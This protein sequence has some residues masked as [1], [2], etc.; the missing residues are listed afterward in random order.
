MARLWPRDKS[1]KLLKTPTANLGRN[2][3]P[4]HPD[5]RKKGGHGP[6]L[7]DEACFLLDVE[8]GADYGGDFSPSE[9]WGDFAPAVRRWEVLTGQP[10]PV[11]VEYGPRGGLRLAPRF[12]EWLMGVL[13]G[14]ITKVPGLDRG[15][16]L[17][18][19]G[20]GVVPQQAYAAFAH[21]MGELEGRS[22]ASVGDGP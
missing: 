6:T 20:D 15:A 16:Q 5:K 12:A 18:A 11:P 17:K 9:W 8:P 2:G 19:I 21:L 7:E 22:R 13:D 3:A 14:W 1:E 4:Q 10:A